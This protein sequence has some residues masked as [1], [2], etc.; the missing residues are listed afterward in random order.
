MIIFGPAEPHELLFIYIEIK[1][2]P[3]HTT[4]TFGKNMLD[5]LVTLFKRMNIW[6]RLTHELNYLNHHTTLELRFCGM[7]WKVQCFQQTTICRRS[8]GKLMDQLTETSFQN[9]SILQPEFFHNLYW[10]VFYL[11]TT[12]VLDSFWNSILQFRY[13][14]IL[15]LI[16]KVDSNICYFLTNKIR[17]D[18]DFPGFVIDFLPGN[19]PWNTYLRKIFRIVWF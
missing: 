10:A 19:H 16:W 6:S 7:N 17:I 3:E 13:S 14:R 1:K 18:G 9:P 11:F 2:N 5:Q 4:L 12:S 15:V 8:N